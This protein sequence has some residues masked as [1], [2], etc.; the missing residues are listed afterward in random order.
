V[1]REYRKGLKKHTCG[2]PVLRISR[3]EVMFSTFTTW[4]AARPEVQ[5][6]VAHD[7]VQT[8]D[9]DLND[10]LGGYYGVEC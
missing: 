8:Q 6:P 3:V 9:F 4:G 2:A 7:E 10:E 1:N 5:D